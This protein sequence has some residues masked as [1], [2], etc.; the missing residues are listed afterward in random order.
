M[1]LTIILFIYSYNRQN[2]M[3]EIKN[4]LK[5]TKGLEIDQM[6]LKMA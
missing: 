3:R 5:L 1:I 4:N 6:E 2:N